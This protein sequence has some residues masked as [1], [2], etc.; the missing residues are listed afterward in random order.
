VSWYSKCTSRVSDQNIVVR[1][2]GSAKKLPNHKPSSQKR[3]SQGAIQNNNETVQ[4]YR[5]K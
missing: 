5:Q 1:D 3:I 4:K 2:D